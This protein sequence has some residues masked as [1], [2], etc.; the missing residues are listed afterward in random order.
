MGSITDFYFAAKLQV[1][2]FSLLFLDQMSTHVETSD[3]S[4][5]EFILT[6]VPILISEQQTVLMGMKVFKLKLDGE[7]ILLIFFLETDN[8]FLDGLLPLFF[9]LF[10]HLY[11][12][13]NT[14]ISQSHIH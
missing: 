1:N 11:F 9:Q 10:H 3:V 13:Y 14:T 8:P 2:G 5:V 4:L 12:F 7:R 6:T